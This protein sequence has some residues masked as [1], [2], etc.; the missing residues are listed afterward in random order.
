MLIRY[1]YSLFSSR[2]SVIKSAPIGI[3]EQIQ[4]VSSEIFSQ[5]Y[6]DEN[7]STSINTVVIDSRCVIMN[8]P[9]KVP[10]KMKVKRQCLY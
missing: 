2:A 1:C 7:T 9:L 6:A 3:E 8:S 5:K 4:K 10:S